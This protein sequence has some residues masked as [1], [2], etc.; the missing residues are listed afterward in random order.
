MSIQHIQALQRVANARIAPR[1]APRPRP[2]PSGVHVPSC[3]PG[4]TLYVVYQGNYWKYTEFYNQV[5]LKRPE[6]IDDVCFMCIGNAAQVPPPTPTGVHGIPQG[7]GIPGPFGPT[8]DTKGSKLD[9]GL[10]EVSGTQVALHDPNI[11][12]TKLRSG[13]PAQV[14]GYFNNQY[15]DNGGKVVGTPDTVAADGQ[16]ANASGLSW[17][18]VGIYDQKVPLYGKTGWVALKYLAPQGWTAAH[19]GTQ[20]N[21]PAVVKLGNADEG[22][23]NAPPVAMTGEP[24]AAWKP[25][26]IGGVAA[27]AVLG[28]GYL[29]LSSKGGKKARRRVKARARLHRMRRRGTGRRRARA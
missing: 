19:G 23:S 7:L 4:Y 17:A 27:L 24:S 26:L 16:V 22:D 2:L 28:G 13:D 9:A 14:V 25:W 6:L 15:G 29:L 8:L 5:L 12:P 18:F 1:M 21:P 3:P 11:D 10:Y 20:P